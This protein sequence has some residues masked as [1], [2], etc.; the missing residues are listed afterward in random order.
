M[1]LSSFERK[2]SQFE[3]F[4]LDGHLFLATAVLGGGWDA[5]WAGFQYFN[6]QLTGTES[7]K[8]LHAF[9]STME[10]VL[11]HSFK[12]Q[13]SLEG[14]RDMVATSITDYFERCHV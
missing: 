8:P 7:L 3:Y 6:A 5:E 12:W 13:L 10:K 4:A 9:C 14:G 1:Y 2:K 11:L